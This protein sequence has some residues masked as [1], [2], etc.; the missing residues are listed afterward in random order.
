LPITIQPDS[1]RKIQIKFKPKTPGQKQAELEILSNAD[2]DSILKIPITARKELIDFVSNTTT[3][4]L[5]YLCPN[6]RKDT[7]II[8]TNTGTIGAG[9]RI[10][11]SSL[12]SSKQSSIELLQNQSLPIEINFIGQASE[13]VINEQITISDTL[14]NVEKKVEIKGEVSLPK[15]EIGDISISTLVGSSK[16]GVLK[17]KNTGKREVI[18]NQIKGIVSPFTTNVQLPIKLS[19]GEEKEI[20]IT[21]SPTDSQRAEITLEI[22]AEP[23]NM[24]KSVKVTGMPFTASAMLKTIEVEGYPGDEVKVPIVLEKEENLQL[25][26]VSAI[27]VEME[28]NPTL[29]Y[30]KSLP[31]D[32]IND[33]LAKVKIEDLPLNKDEGETLGEVVFVVG[34]GNAEECDL[35]LSNAVTKGGQAE[36]TLR[37]GHFRLLG[38]CREGGARLVNPYAKV[39]IVNIVPNPADESVTIEVLLTENGRTELL[40]YNTIGEVMMELIK[41]SKATR[42]LRTTNINTNRLPTGQYILQLRT[43]TYIESRIVRIIR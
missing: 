21:Y 13:G 5:G 33:T 3:I 10:A 26:R 43:P 36:I 19:V 30:P 29:L 24:Q 11:G 15:L 17:I 41:E 39:G 16:D 38:V 22:I 23:C 4:D 20:A 37:N 7:S 42:G 6:E 40:L 28:F 9:F 31:V 18:I 27:D 2:P 32:V 25:A 14:C 1:S 12:I 34:L 8:I 35:R